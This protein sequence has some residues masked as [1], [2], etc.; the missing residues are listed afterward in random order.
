MMFMF[1]TTAQATLP[2]LTVDGTV[3]TSSNVDDVLGDGKVVYNEASQTLVLSDVNIPHGIVIDAKA[4]TGPFTI[5]AEGHC[6]V[7]NEDDIAIWYKGGDGLVI[8]G[9][10]EDYLSVMT[11]Y[12]SGGAHH[13]IYCGASE[14]TWVDAA[15]FIVTGGINLSVDNYSSE[16]FYSAIG[17]DDYEIHKSSVA[18]Y[19]HD[20]TWPFSTLSGAHV[21]DHVSFIDQKAEAYAYPFE[22]G[23]PVWINGMQMSDGLPKDWSTGLP[24]VSGLEMKAITSGAIS[25][26]SYNA[27]TREL[28]L[29]GGV[30]LAAEDYHAIEIHNTEDPSAAITIKRGPTFTSNPTEIVSKN[31]GY[32]ALHALTPVI[33]DANGSSIRF[34]AEYDNAMVVEDK[35]TL[36]NSDLRNENTAELIIFGEG[37]SA[38]TSD[39]GNGELILDHV[40]MNIYGSGEVISKL[41]NVEM[42]PGLRF[43]LP[44][45]YDFAG[46][47]LVEKGTTNIVTHQQLF[48]VLNGWYFDAIAIPEGAGSFV[49]K[50]G[51][52]E[53]KPLPYLFTADEQ[54][55]IEVKANAGWEFGK[56]NDWYGS[57]NPRDVWMWTSSKQSQ[58]YEAQFSRNIESNE[59]FYALERYDR[60]IYP[61]AEHL[62]YL[63]Y[64][65]VGLVPFV[66]A[67]TYID[68]AVAGNGKLYAIE[69]DAVNGKSG[70]ISFQFDGKNITNTTGIVDLQGKYNPIRTIAFNKSEKKLYMIAYD[71]D[72]YKDVLLS[73]DPE[74]ETAFTDLGELSAGFDGIAMAMAFDKSNVLYVFGLPAI[75]PTL[76]TLD[77]ASKTETLLGTLDGVSAGYGYDEFAMLFSETTGELFLKA[78]FNLYLVDPSLVKAE[79]ISGI[80]IGSAI[81]AGETR[82]KVY[83]HP[84]AGQEGWGYVDLTNGYNPTYLLPGEELQAYAQPYEGYR[85]VKWA[86]GETENPRDW[87]VPEA[88]TELE[89]V[90]EEITKHTITVESNDLMLGTAD[91]KYYGS[92]YGAYEGQELVLEA[93][94]VS[95]FYAFVK[96]DDENTDNPRTIVV[97][98]EDKTYTAIFETLPTYTITV[99]ADPNGKAEIEGYSSPAVLPQGFEVNLI[100]TPTVAG[101]VFDKWEDGVT[102]NP[103]TITVTEDK[104]FTAEFKAGV[105]HTI[106]GKVDDEH[107]WY[108]DVLLPGGVTT[109]EYAEGTDVQLTVVIDY[110]YV[111][112]YVF[113]HWADLLDTD[114]DYAANPRTITVGT[115]DATYEAVLMKLETGEVYLSVADGQDFWGKVA[116]EESGYSSYYGVVGNVIHAVATPTSDK[117][118]FVKWQD[119]NTDNPRA[120]TVTKDDQ[121]F[122]ATFAKKDAPKPKH[123]ITVEVAA[124]DEAKGDVNIN[125]GAKSGEFEEGA[126]ITL[127]AVANTGYVFDKW[128]D[129]NTEENRSFTVG[130]TDETFVASFKLDDAPKHTITVSVAAGQEAMGDVDINGGAKTGEF[131]EGKTITLNAKPN[132]GYKFVKWNDENTDKSRSFTVG[133]EDKEFIASF[134]EAPAPVGYPVTVADLQLDEEH[135]TLVAGTDLVGILKAGSITYDPTTNTLILNNV[136][137]EFTDPAHTIQVNGGEAKTKVN[138]VIVGNCK[139]T[140]AGAG[141]YLE[142]SVM[143]TLSGD[144]KL[145]IKSDAYGIYLD[146][147]DLTLDGIALIIDATNHGILGDTSKEKLIVNGAAISVKGGYGSIVDLG[148]MELNYC[149]FQTGYDFKNNQVEKGGSVTTDAVILDVWPML[150]V[151]AVEDGTAKFTLTSKKTKEEFTNKGWFEDGDE[152][153][154][155]TEVADGYVFGHWKDDAD[156][157]DKKLR[158]KADRKFDKGAGNET[159]TALCYYEA[160]SDADWFGIN[161]NEF[162]KFSFSDNAEKVARANNSLSDVLGGDF[163]DGKWVYVDDGDVFGFSFSGTLKDGASISD[164]YNDKFNKKSISTDVTD[165]AYDILNDDLYAVAGSKLY[166]VTSS[167]NKEV[168]V[169]KLDDVETD[170]IAI[171]FDADGVLYALGLGDGTE[172]VLYTT[173]VAKEMKLKAVG[174]KENNGKIGMKV[175]NKPQS[176]AFDPATGELFWGAADYIRV[177]D[178]SKMKTH[179][180]GDLDQKDGAQGF[181]KSLHRMAIAVEVTVEV[182]KEQASWGYA[183]VG[184]ESTDAKNRTASARFIEGATVTITATANDGYHFV[185]WQNADD[186]KDRPSTATYEFEAEEVTYIAV[187]EEG[188]EGI[189]SITIDPTKNVQKVLID[190][191][192]YI[193][194]D[195]RVYTVTGELMQ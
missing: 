32:C 48:F 109:A 152:V 103:R 66:A 187:F 169:F 141:L 68:G 70:L 174:K 35:L 92:P 108:G 55:S 151:K 61:Y 195:G 86:D 29:D 6:F 144:G 158:M 99:I 114:P 38:V 185:E 52:D 51:A 140:T 89:A 67:E 20:D 139:I 125:G 40:E 136:E 76:Y 57:D 44:D 182:D 101:Y 33:V 173:D 91:I 73:I 47:A 115:S 4:L 121:Y 148:D 7:S 79:W 149:S 127:N 84:A 23:Y 8:T 110:W 126:T 117:Y 133:T 181:I 120:I 111:G 45:D 2:D 170:I 54:G 119:D 21:L 58:I 180:A 13:A 71:T 75:V 97:G 135:A 12:G 80:A 188:S 128:N 63:P 42:K 64:E 189:Q 104:T 143:I 166:K 24:Y 100:A 83:A 60:G 14:S 5:K 15:K 161:D 132:S 78:T 41:A 22:V 150:T 77:V 87:T 130:T 30:V 72:L 69:Y 134:E 98:T 177:I 118:E 9:S 81:F 88:E 11:L 167:D 27:A 90:F 62:R 168:G 17:C 147:A 82:Y 184:E 122:T 172:G 163:V 18:V 94:P 190:G 191:T 145:D 107:K 74:S 129:D 155:S 186:K 138:I 156:W 165:M 142:N 56:W 3:V 175:D 43:A 10:S 160:Q 154:I 36:T 96:W 164:K 37:G 39:F 157:K 46:G 26:I 34:D 183:T 102:D 28:I 25:T 19:T 176:I 178:L 106:T 85:F 1:V 93:D 59:T 193:F 112:E 31:S 137:I 171:A 159:L 194:R 179:I 124:G 162:V 53:E 153:T 50:N 146:D 123:T 49:F 105:A 116:F 113:D 192:I 95:P 65:K 131:A 16:V